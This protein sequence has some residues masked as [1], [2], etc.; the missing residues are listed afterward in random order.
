MLSAK[1]LLVF[2]LPFIFHDGAESWRRRRRRRACTPRDCQVS[3]WYSWN[4]CSVSTCGRQGSQSRSRSVASYASCAGASCPNLYE[5][6]HCYG[7]NSENCQLSSWSQWSACTA[8]RCG[9]SAMQTSTR[10]RITTEKCG[11]WCTTIFRKTQK[12]FRGPTNCELSSWSEWNTCNGTVCTAGHGTQVSFRNKTIKETCG[13]TCTSTLRKTRNC[14]KSITRIAVECQLS[15]WSEWG[16][17]KRTS[18]QL[19]GIQTRTRKK[20]VKEECPGTCK[21]A[22]HQTKLC[23]QPR[24]PCF[25]GGTYK[26]NITGCVCMQGYYGVC[27]LQSSESSDGHGNRD[28]TKTGAI[29]ISVSI[30]GGVFVIII[31]ICCLKCGVC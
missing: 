4:S 10:H 29:T 9:S 2:I 16:D 1:F 17:C 24:L 25:N 23:T 26:P 21:Y 5:S 13:G 12:C 18:C 19:S 7:S 31:C 30:S 27:C 28:S 6:R 15:P 8:I 22:L 14:T 11:G 20:I 3:S